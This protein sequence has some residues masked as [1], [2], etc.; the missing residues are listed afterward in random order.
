[1]SASRST[2]LPIAMASRMMRVQ[3]SR[4]RRFPRTRYATAARITDNL[5]TTG[6]PVFSSSV[7]NL[8]ATTTPCATPE[9]LPRLSFQAE[10][11]VTKGTLAG[12]RP[13]RHTP[14]RYTCRSR[15]SSLCSAEVE[16][17]SNTTRPTGRGS[18]NCLQLRTQLVSRMAG[19]VT[20]VARRR[21]RTFSSSSDDTSSKK[22]EGAIEEEEEKG[23]LPPV[24]EAEIIKPGDL[25]QQQPRH[26]QIEMPAITDVSVPCGA[27]VPPDFPPPS[28]IP[29]G[30]LPAFI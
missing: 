7:H 30:R 24:A 27:V 22:S 16:R 14:P 13:T 8:P 12:L 23:D 29:R 6:R 18:T 9:M 15:R 25:T 20:Y 4:S 1:M 19:P 26:V 10:K 17:T 21:R 28:L 3:L 5:S 2:R 11:L